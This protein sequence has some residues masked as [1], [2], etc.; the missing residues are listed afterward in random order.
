VT[1]GLETEGAWRMTLSTPPG[2]SHGDPRQHHAP[3]DVLEYQSRVNQIVRLSLQLDVGH[4]TRPDV[5]FEA[6]IRKAFAEAKQI[7]RIDIDGDHA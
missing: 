6:W 4:I 7:L 3:C 2:L 5:K 1:A